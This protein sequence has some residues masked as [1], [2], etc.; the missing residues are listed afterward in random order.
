DGPFFAHSLRENAAALGRRNPVRALAVIADE[1]GAT[2]KQHSLVFCLAI[3]GASPLPAL[4][5]AQQ[6]P[7]SKSQAAQPTEQRD[8][9]A[10]AQERTT[11][12]SAGDLKMEEKPGSLSQQLANSDGVICPPARVDPDINAPTPKGGSMQ[13]IRP[14]DNPDVRPK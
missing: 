1:E 7:Q 10:C 13:V 5:F 11:V 2:M 4:A 8:P 9:K 14:D 12:G 6:P 3:L